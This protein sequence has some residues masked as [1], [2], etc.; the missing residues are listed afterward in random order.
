MLVA[1][2]KNYEKIVSL[3]NTEEIYIE[4][5][6]NLIYNKNEELQ[7][8]IICNTKNIIKN[9]MDKIL[10]KKFYANLKNILN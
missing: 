5:F 10:V 1:L 4:K 6:S 2:L 7:T 8:L 3:Y 9:T